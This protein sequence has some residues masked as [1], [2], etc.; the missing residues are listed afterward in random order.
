[1]QNIYGQIGL[2]D[3]VAVIDPAKL[4]WAEL[5][6]GTKIGETV[7]VFPRMDKNKVMS[8]IKEQIGSPAE[9]PVVTEPRLDSNCGR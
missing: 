4:K 2:T 5:A 8:E 3:D 9:E 7:G 1:M 6:P